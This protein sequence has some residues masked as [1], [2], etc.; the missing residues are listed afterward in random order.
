MQQCI[1]VPQSHVYMFRQTLTFV[2]GKFGLI[3][4]NIFKDIHPFV[5]WKKSHTQKESLL[6]F[7]QLP[8]FHPSVPAKTSS[9]VFTLV[10]ETT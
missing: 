4:S 3:L 2:L 6:T 1:V 7:L 9:Q 8:D 5:P 10:S